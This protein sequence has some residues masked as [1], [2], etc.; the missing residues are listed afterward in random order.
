[1]LQV[2]VLWEILWADAWEEKA[3]THEHKPPN[4]Y[5]H[6]NNTS[7]CTRQLTAILPSFHTS[8]LRQLRLVHVHSLCNM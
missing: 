1:M 6:T 2:L 7:V 8:H 3:M 4:G 5:L